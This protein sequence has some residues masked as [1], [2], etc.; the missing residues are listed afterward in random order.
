MKKLRVAII[1]LAHIH[2]HNLSQDFNK[3]PESIEW[4]GIADVPPYTKEQLEKRLKLND[5]QVGD[6][7]LFENYKELLDQSPDLAIICTDIK[8]H[9][10][11][12]EETLARGIHTVVEK[13]M[14]TTIEDGVRMYR[15]AMKSKASLAINWPVAWFNS[16][17]TAYE[18]TKSGIVGQPLRFQYRSPATLGPYPSGKYSNAELSELWWYQHNRGGGSVFDYAGYGCTLA[19]WFLGKTAKKVSGIKKNFLLPFSD[20]EDYSTFT[21][22]FGSSV[23]IIEGS[24]STLSNGE[25]PT[26][27]IIYGSE[28]VIVADRYDKNVKVYKDVIPYKPSPKPNQIIPVDDLDDNIGQHMI[29]HI[30][31]NAPLHELL[32]A[33]FNLKAMAALVA[34]IRSCKSGNMEKVINPFEEVVVYE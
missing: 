24:W 32:T 7:K 27:P 3:Y 13:P 15:A 23:A 12:V 16:F 26:G 9:A 10:D 17:R 14:A 31:N 30:H 21:I 25:I 8:G 11:I 20:V 19:T 33:E 18:L 5:P 22:D 6:A 34:G 4:A 28:G 29:N 1:G 2:A